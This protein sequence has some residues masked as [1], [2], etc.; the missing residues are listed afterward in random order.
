M[1]TGKIKEALGDLQQQRELIDDAIKSL[2]RV[3]LQLNGHDEQKMLPLALQTAPAIAQGTYLDLVVQLIEANGYRPMHVKN[4]VEQIRLLRNNPNIRRQAVEATLQK[5]I[6]SKGE[7][8]RV[9][10]DSPGHYRVRR[11]PRTLPAA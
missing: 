6:A 1:N 5:H 4:I 7:M 8:S 3:L 10:K 2:Q 11:M 9:A